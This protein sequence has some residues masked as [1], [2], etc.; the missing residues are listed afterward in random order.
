MRSKDE[1]CILSEV[2][3]IVKTTLKMPFNELDVN[4]EFQSLNMNS[5]VTAELIASL[6]KKFAISITEEQFVKS[7]SVKKI[8]DF[9]SNHFVNRKNEINNLP[10]PSD[11]Q[12][13]ISRLMTN[14]NDTFVDYPKDKCIHHL[15]AEQV[16]CNPGKT[17][18]V[19]NQEKLTY[20]QLFDKSYKLALYLQ[21]Q[22]V[23]PDCLVGL[24]IDRSPNMLIGIFGILLAG[25]AYVPIDL[26]Y[27]DDRL[28]H[29]LRD[30]RVAIILSEEKL[31]HKLSVL[32]ESETQIVALDRQWSEINDH[33]EALTAQNVK[34]QEEVK[35]NNL[36]Y[37]IYTSGSTGQ[38]K[39][40]MVEH[41]SLVNHNCYATEKY[42]ITDV[43]KQIQ[44][45]S[46][47]FDL[48]VEEVFV[49]LNNGAQ[50]ILE[51]KDNLLS[52]EYFGKMIETHQVTILNLP[53]AFFHQLVAENIQLGSVNKVVIGGEKLDHL[54]AKKFISQY[55]EVDL[56]NTYGPTETTIIS[57]AITVTKDLI[58]QRK[59]VPIGSPIANTQIYILD[60]N[61]NLQTIGV[62]GELHIGGDGLARGYLN[63]PELTHE[64]FIP[65]P[66]DSDPANSD[67]RLYKT[68]DLACW[69]ED[70][71]IEY[72][73]RIDNQVKIRGFRIETGEIEAEL[74]Q[75]LEIKDS[76]VVAQGEGSNAQLV[77]FYVAA[78]TA[79]VHGEDIINLASEELRN[80][81][82]QTLPEYMLPIAFVSLK[83]IPLTVNGKVNRR[84]LEG[85]VV[86]LESNQ[87]YQAPRNDMESRLVT[88]WSKVLNR[89]PDT[90]GINDNFF[91]LGGHSLLATQLISKVR[92]QFVI[93]L[94]I[95][96][97]FEKA[98]V[99]QLIQLILK[100]DKSNIP[101]ILPIEKT[102]FEQLPLSFV[103]GRLWFIDQLEPGNSSYNIPAAISIDGELDAH[104]L[105][106]AL[107][108]II[109]RH[110]NLRTI[111]PS[112]DGQA[113]QV[114]LDRLDFSLEKIDLSHYKCQEESDKKAKQLCQNE[115]TMPFDL[116][117]GPLIRGKIITLTS[118]AHI[119]MLNIHHIIGDDWSLGILYKELNLIM[120]ALRQGTQV[121]LPPLPIQY[122]DYSVWQRKWLEEGVL[123]RQLSYWQEKLAD[124]PESLDLVRDY[125]RP[126]TQSLSGA[127]HA[128][129]F[130]V[131][132]TGQLKS[133]VEEQN[134]T[135]F[136]GLLSVFK[137]LLYRYTG[138]E[139]ICVGSVIANRQYE[140]TEGLIGMFVNTL[141]LRNFMEEEDTFTTVLNKVKTTCLEA[142]EHQDAPFEKIVD[143]VQPRRNI[144]INPLFQIMVVLQNAQ[145]EIVDE[146][147][148]PYHLDKNTSKF[149]LTLEFTETSKGLSGSIDYS[150][151]LYK[152]QTIER[153]VEHFIALCRSITASPATKI[154]ELDYIG[155]AEKQRLLID[156]NQTQAD[157]PK[158]KCIHQLFAEQVKL[159]PD[160]IA[161]VYE[162]EQLGAQ[163]LSYQQ[164]Y[165]KSNELALYLQ[166]QGVKPDSL[167]GLCVER[168]LDM[169]VG[170]LGIVQSGGAYV[171]LDPDYPDHRLS[172]M[173][174]DSQ[175]A[176][177]L[178]QEKF[179]N[180][181]LDLVGADT[182]LIS[183]DKQ[184][185]EISDSVAN[186][187]AKNTELLEEVKSDNLVYVIYTSGSTGQPKGVMVEHRMVVDYSY[188]VLNKMEL[189]CCETFAHL[190]TFAADLGNLAL[191]VPIIFSK[192]VYLFSNEVINDPIKLFN[193]M[194][195]Y[196][197]DCMKITPSHFE[198]FT[199][200]DTQV[201]LPSKVLILAGEALSRKVIDTVNSIN[202]RCKVFNNYGPTETTVS[203][204]S[205]SV[206]ND[207]DSLN[208]PLGKPLNNTQ[209]YIL[210]KNNKLQPV[211]IPGEL[212]IAG[213]GLARGY[214]N[215]AGLTKEKFITNSFYAGTLM[216]K[217]GDMARW[218]D[219]G[220]I[221]Y[222]GRID[223]QVKIRGFRIEMGEIENQ[224]NTHSKI[225]DCVVVVQGEE[226]N[227]R[228]ILF[229]V[230]TGTSADN[231]IHLCHKE[232]RTHLQRTLP[233]Y[234]LPAAF[235]SLKAIP[236]NANGKVE[237]RT[238][239]QIDVSIESSQIYSPPRND[240]EKQLVNI[241]AQVL[242]LAPEKIGVNDSFFEL[243]GHSLLATQ[244]IS[245]IRNQLEIDMPLKAIFNANTIAGANEAINA[246]KYQNKQLLETDDILNVEFE[247][248]TL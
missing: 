49:I 229:Y 124:V 7:N 129:T 189:N 35:P 9:I 122:V 158:D 6:S 27:P 142:Y 182:Q 150:T 5:I 170:I 162:D 34:L 42:Q 30:S 15:F 60:L 18:V 57:S 112:L 161:V 168:S 159:N 181:L 184:W 180:K 125:P 91:E 240:T 176:I 13:S 238:L 83:A 139:D 153:M 242:N 113:Q 123:E 29:M 99:A 96:D 209:V 106:Q 248:G 235:V 215:R 199:I 19:F 24:S 234:M 59:N 172:Y 169:M 187:K 244:V 16:K 95:K 191:Y 87:V 39:G 22:R 108:L 138:Q 194:K 50:L 31:K 111:F 40:V 213:D 21:S 144:A 132:L 225:K 133:M 201:V 206:L 101:P 70:G 241:W 103:Q 80:H 100:S 208:V 45:S 51:Q 81:L 231:V 84:K 74:N 247:E 33:F 220:N 165:D 146:D 78:K 63:R 174:K 115:A 200:S 110:D 171:P 98:S 210:D 104:Q 23:K 166:S 218:L 216:Y 179:Q 128:F 88:I 116:A 126:K 223:T 198:M 151:A 192:T 156:F 55:P 211:G 237:R 25:G 245:K 85:T 145:M 11:S 177:L 67:S 135:L 107:N 38:P 224:L 221:E 68:G 233:E 167:V 203:K 71:N 117:I 14:F 102:E 186:L 185:T 93:D 82:Q 26:N 137:T 118:Q 64:K 69:L 141:A 32:V 197:I 160:K 219:D 163:R 72:L 140:E 164:L 41:R 239:E 173:L 134:A 92:S 214:F 77:A 152:P 20:Q 178:T 127:S 202:P 130:D 66:F 155:K 207:I 114:I 8:A 121:Y 143:L 226:I 205:T 149:D 190:S 120:D 232:L 53:T 17:A 79:V 73:G 46:I 12:N 54:K 94:Q 4:S 62:P 44:F 48:F 37:V 47:S 109:A 227:K 105:E 36:A 222:L 136:M 3:N 175:A 119:L 147:I 131:Q 90:I 236:L 157:Y 228:L 89:E 230:V 183:L 76:V 204:L 43:D 86:K 2:C 10:C 154:G 217:T 52:L 28:R 196:S 56:Y 58:N 75:Y 212:H 188:S 148:R 246:I 243:G 65:N 193:H 61:N 1:L 195:N 97:I